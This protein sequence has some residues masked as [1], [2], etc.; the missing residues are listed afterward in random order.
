MW[1]LVMERAE[2]GGIVNTALERHVAGCWPVPGTQ[3]SCSVSSW[4]PLGGLE[5]ALFPDLGDHI[6]FS[7]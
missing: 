6:L 7:V 3:D 1:Q 4:A 2:F 5:A